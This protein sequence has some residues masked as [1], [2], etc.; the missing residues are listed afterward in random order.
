MQEI[1]RNNNTIH[2]P[3]GGRESEGKGKQKLYE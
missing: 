3:V 2:P 1:I